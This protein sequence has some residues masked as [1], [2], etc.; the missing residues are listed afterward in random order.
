M[1]DA[2]KQL[3]YGNK[4]SLRNQVDAVDDLLDLYV[5][6][7]GDAFP[8]VTLWRSG[9][10]LY[11]SFTIAAQA[12]VKMQL[13]GINQIKENI[14]KCSHCGKPHDKSILEWIYKEYIA[15]GKKAL[16]DNG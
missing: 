11:N 6:M 7:L 5:A 3:S 8:D 4:M 13:L 10:V 12:D 1:V 14:E 2:L 16:K 15:Y 9:S